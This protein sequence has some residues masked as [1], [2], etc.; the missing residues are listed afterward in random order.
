MNGPLPTPGPLRVAL[1]A[2]PWPLLNRPSIQLGTLKAYLDREAGDWLQADLFHPYTEVAR[3]LGPE[4]YHWLS[5][6]SWASEALYASLLFP[7]REVQAAELVQEAVRQSPEP[8]QLDF[9]TVKQKLG[10]QLDSWLASIDWRPY[11]LIGFSVCFHQLFSSLTAANR[12]KQLS[13]ASR[14]VFGGSFCA[15][16]VS[17]SLLNT[18]PALDYTVQ[19][20]GEQ[21]LLDLCRYLSGRRET[22]PAAVLGREEGLAADSSSFS[23]V[24]NLAEL[25]SPD[26]QAYFA[27]IGRHF[28]GEPFIPVLPVEFSRGCWWRKCAFCNLNLQWSGYRAKRASRMQEE[29]LALAKQFGCLD[30]AFTDNALPPAEARIFF[31]GMATLEQ[32]IRFF[33]EI[34]VPQHPEE[35]A[36][37]RQGGLETVQVGIESLSNSLLRKM[38]KG[39]CVLDNIAAMKNCLAAG[40]VLEGNLIT[41]FP[42][43]T[44]EEA[45]ETL[46][47]L[48]FVL[49]FPPLAAAGFFLGH[50]S[51]VARDPASFGVKQILPHRQYA[52]LIPPELLAGL[53]L[54]TNDYR[55]D[56]TAQRRQWA[57]VRRKIKEWRSFHAGRPQTR[58]HKPALSYREGGDFLIIRQELPGRTLHHRLRGTS[59]EIFLFCGEVREMREL[60]QRFPAVPEKKL[61]SFLEDLHCKRLVFA[62]NDRYLSLAIREH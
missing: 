53:T 25:P 29:V 11:G 43:S 19:G 20:E 4:L 57:P 13:P 40:I 38:A 59:R 49:P 18:F 9:T 52:R 47:N 55:G 45:A 31:Q 27:E 48:D 7:D 30:F 60:C 35:L 1:V 12:L 8:I 2:M 21:P 22:R 50:G 5:R 61:R 14:I 58:R 6:H 62:E 46:H 54:L 23:Q 3:L 15:Q 41:E 34:R 16:A 42:E 39:T 33:G 36:C 26:Y 51:P 10:L 28:A 17:A 56:R 32:D 24:T 37:Y 44:A